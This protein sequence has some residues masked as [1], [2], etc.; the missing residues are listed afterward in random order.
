MTRHERVC[1]EGGKKEEECMRT[2]DN[3]QNVVGVM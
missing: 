1:E 2:S 3:E